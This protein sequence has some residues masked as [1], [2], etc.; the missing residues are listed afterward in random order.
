LSWSVRAASFTLCFACLQDGGASTLCQHACGVVVLARYVSMLAGWWCQHAMFACLQG[1]G[2]SSVLNCVWAPLCALAQMCVADPMSCHLQDFTL[3]KSATSCRGRLRKVDS[4]GA[5]LRHINAFHNGIPQ[6]TLYKCRST[7]GWR[8]AEGVRLMW[9]LS[10]SHQC[11]PQCTLYACRCTPGWRTAE[12]VRLMW[13]FSASHQCIPQCTLYACRCTPGWRMAEEVRLMWCLSASRQCI[14]QCTLCA[15]RS[16]P[17]PED[18]P[19]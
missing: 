3:C 5:C 19:H 1:V 15:C 13:C 14:P 9:C 11:I 2:A 10:A 4:C 16:A 17:N 18:V 8:T 7:P 6:C 12:G